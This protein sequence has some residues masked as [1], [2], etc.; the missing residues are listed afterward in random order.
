MPGRSTGFSGICRANL[1]RFD[2]D[3]VRRRRV[4]EVLDRAEHAAHVDGEVRLRKSAVLARALDNRAG[5][6]ILAERVDRDAR[7][8]A[9]LYGGTERRLGLVWSVGSAHRN[10]A[11]KRFRS[12]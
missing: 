2:H 1:A 12:R 3:D 9:V 10:L 11:P 6:R 5:V 4:L 8:R 7:N